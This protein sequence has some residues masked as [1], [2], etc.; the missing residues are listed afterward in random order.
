MSDPK[1]KVAANENGLGKVRGELGL[2]RVKRRAQDLFD[3]FALLRVVAVARDIDHAIDKFAMRVP[4]HEET[5]LAPF[6]DSIDGGHRVVKLLDAGLEQLIS[7]K[8]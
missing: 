4:A 3:F 6:L 7:R 1:H 8:Q 5:G 2:L